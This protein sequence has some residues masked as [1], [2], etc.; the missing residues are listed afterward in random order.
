M[1][2]AY[3]YYTQETLAQALTRTELAKIMHAPRLTVSNHIAKNMIRDMRPKLYHGRIVFI[4]DTTTEKMLPPQSNDSNNDTIYHVYKAT[5][6]EYICP[7]TL[8]LLRER[9]GIKV[10]AMLVR[11]VDNYALYKYNIYLSRECAPDGI[12]PPKPVY[13]IYTHD[14]NLVLSTFHPKLY[15]YWKPESVEYEPNEYKPNHYIAK[16][17][18]G[19]SVP[20]DIPHIDYNINI[21]KLLL[22]NDKNI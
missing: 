12:K 21:D 11:C 10:I 3:D 16:L 4:D 20:R 18:V 1:Y 13:E 19:H 14:N 5:T 8:P 7:V 17:P 2:I 22:D 15:P 9:L 6:G